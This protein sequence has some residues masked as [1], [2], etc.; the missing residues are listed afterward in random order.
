MDVTD[1]QYEDGSFDVIYCSHVLEH[2]PDD[3]KAMA[4]FH[5]VLKPDG[6]A[7][8]LVPIT[9][10]KTIEDPS[11]TAPED[12]LRLFGQEDH[13]R[14][15]GPDYIDRLINAGFAVKE[16]A[17]TDFLSERGIRRMEVQTHVAGNIFLC[18]KQSTRSCA[19]TN[20]RYRGFSR[21]SSPS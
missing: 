13:V 18:T 15:Y 6:W 1:I 10:S 3:R 4:E 9:A 8:L 19:E 5:R 12:R 7:I 16:I 21:S 17:A 11:V 20:P 2:V 14:K